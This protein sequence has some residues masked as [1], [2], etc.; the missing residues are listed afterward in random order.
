MH[1]FIVACAISCV[2][3]AG[4]V[5]AQAPPDIKGNWVAK[6]A[7]CGDLKLRIISQSQSGIITGSVLCGRTGEAQSFG[8]KL[9]AGK[10]MAGKFD[11]T[12]LNIEGSQSLTSVKFDGTRLVGF[13]YGGPGLGT[14]PVAFV[15]Q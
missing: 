8:Q 10:Q 9:I 15:K 11:G 4:V 1:R 14:T 6:T 13:A 7:G 5:L 2:L 12:Y 3:P